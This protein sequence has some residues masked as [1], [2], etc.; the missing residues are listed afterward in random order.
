[1]NFAVLFM[2]SP[3]NEISLC[4]GHYILDNIKCGLYSIFN[5]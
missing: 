4:E 5:T 3:L 1:M 2:Q